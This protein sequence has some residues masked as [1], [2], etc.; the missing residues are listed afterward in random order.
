[1]LKGRTVRVSGLG[2]VRVRDTETRGWLHNPWVIAGVT[3][4]GGGIIAGGVLA[5]NFGS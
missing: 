2:T 5:L 3:T 1:M 4:V